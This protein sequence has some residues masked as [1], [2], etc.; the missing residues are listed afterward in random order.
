M[1][2][3]NICYLISKAVITFATKSTKRERRKTQNK[4]NDSLL[5]SEEAS[6]G[7]GGS[8]STGLEGDSED[9]ATDNQI[10]GAPRSDVLQACTLTSG[11]LLAGGLLLR[12]VKL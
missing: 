4:P 3:T 5:T 1:R 8:G 9:A 7:S 11:L 6:S 2:M 12:Q 10:S